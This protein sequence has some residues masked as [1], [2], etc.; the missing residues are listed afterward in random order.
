MNFITYSD[1]STMICKNLY[2]IPSDTDCIIGIPRSGMLPASI[3]SL[4]LN[5]PLTD[6]DSFAKNRNIFSIGNTK[7]ID[8]TK[9]KINNLKKILVVDDSCNGGR[10]L[11]EAKAK[12]ANIDGINFVYLACIVTESSKNLVDLY[13]SIFSQPRLFEWNFMHSK[14]LENSC[15]DIDGVLCLDPTNEQND[16]GE[17]YIDFIQNTPRKLYPTRKIGSIVSCRL[18]KYRSQTEK[19]LEQ[20]KISYNTLVLMKYKTKEDRLK[21]GNHGKFKGNVYKSMENMTLFIESNE[22]QAAEIAKIS[23]KPVFCIDNQTFYNG[24]YIY[25]LKEKTSTSSATLKKELFA[26]SKKILKKILPKKILTTYKKMKLHSKT[27]STLEKK[28]S[29][30]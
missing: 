2:K 28:Y 16:D 9:K 12:L 1:L 20:Q 26:F 8:Y 13:F 18:E 23:G 22:K 29:E 4:S 15:V 5:L 25:N 7:N 30:N 21:N 14:Q 10:A 24:N 17:K 11:R 6:I 27:Q 19:W 3:I